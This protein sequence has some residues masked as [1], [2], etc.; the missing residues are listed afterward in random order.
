MVR[1]FT[2]KTYYGDCALSVIA[3]RPT[4]VIAAPII[5]SGAFIGA[6][7]EEIDMSA[8]QALLDGYASGQKDVGKTSYAFLINKAGVM[9]A[10][11][12]KAQVLKTKPA[13]LGIPQLAKAVKD[14]QEGKTGSTVYTQGGV[15]T[16]IGYNPMKGQGS[17]KGNG[18]AVAA[19]VPTKEIYS[20]VIALRYYVFGLAAAASLVAI[21]ISVL[22]TRVLTGPLAA[23]SRVVSVISGGDLSVTVPEVRSKDEVGTL[24][25]GL[26]SM[27][28]NLRGVVQGIHASAEQVVYMSVGLNGTASESVQAVGQIATTVQQLA[29]A[30]E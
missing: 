2:G 24:A 18:W 15:E 11:Q 25:A 28:E 8:V 5:S 13:E 6:V 10:G 12:D 22:V 20:D 16:L 9:V 26:R 29:A 17:Y 3:K 23:L 19:A 30:A 21:L 27:L 14:M 7:V 4:I 1:C